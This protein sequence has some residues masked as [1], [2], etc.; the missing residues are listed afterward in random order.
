MRPLYN[1][2]SLQT[3]LILYNHLYLIVIPQKDS[4]VFSKLSQVWKVIGVILAKAAKFNGH[5]L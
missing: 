5:I 2:D 4:L 3:L 1:Y